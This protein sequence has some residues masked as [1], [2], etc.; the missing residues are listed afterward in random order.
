MSYLAYHFVV[1]PPQPGSEILVAMIAEM[2]FESF[3]FSDTGF[4]AYINKDEEHNVNFDLLD[5][6]DFTYSYTV[7]EIQTTNWNAEWEKNFEP[8]VVENLLCIRAPF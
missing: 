1:E 3:D 5:F 7:E 2:G 4:S 8:V 6:E